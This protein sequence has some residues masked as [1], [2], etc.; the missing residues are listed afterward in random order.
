M[1]MKA[2]KFYLLFNSLHL[3]IFFLPLFTFENVRSAVGSST[4]KTENALFYNSEAL[5]IARIVSN[6][7]DCC[8]VQQ[9]VCREFL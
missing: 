6:T 8:S 3:F 9:P 4:W 7:W 1:A 5:Q 2:V